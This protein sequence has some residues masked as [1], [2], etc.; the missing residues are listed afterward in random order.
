MLHREASSTTGR[1]NRFVR[2][3]SAFLRGRKLT[4]SYPRLQK[5]T[6]QHTAAEKKA[7]GADYSWQ[8]EGKRAGRDPSSAF[9]KVTC[10]KF[11][12]A[13]H[14]LS[15]IWELFFLAGPTQRLQTRVKQR[16]AGGADRNL[17]KSPFQKL[18]THT[19]LSMPFFPRKKNKMK[20]QKPSSLTADAGS[21][22]C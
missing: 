1:K 11:L 20:E 17:R 5:E 2:P 19:A 8:G 16:Q 14:K 13:H 15:S 21:T 18:R 3:V 4:N 10:S 7:G 6:H 22:C 9:T 12:K